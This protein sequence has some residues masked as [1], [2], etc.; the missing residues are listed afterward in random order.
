MGTINQTGK[1][2]KTLKTQQTILTGLFPAKLR[3]F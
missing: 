2:D 3:C 1:N